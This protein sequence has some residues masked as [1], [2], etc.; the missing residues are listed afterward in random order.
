[1]GTKP[2]FESQKKFASRP[3]DPAK[4]GFKGLNFK[5]S[6]PH[7]TCISPIL[8]LCTLIDTGT[9]C[10]DLLRTLDAAATATEEYQSGA[11]VHTYLQIR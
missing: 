6:H 7:Q 4:P 8:V 5:Q 9:L 11:P 10:R 1:V 2:R 3:L